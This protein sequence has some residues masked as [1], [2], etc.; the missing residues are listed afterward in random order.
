M[1]S[2]G[3]INAHLGP[4]GCDLEAKTNFMSV[5]EVEDDVQPSTR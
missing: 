3:Q 2:L 5:L 4:G 1:C